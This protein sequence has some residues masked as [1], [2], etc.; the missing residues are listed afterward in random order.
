MHQN[1]WKPAPM[2]ARGGQRAR[3]LT[4]WPRFF[5]YPAVTLGVLMLV[6]AVGLSH[7]LEGQGWQKI[8]PASAFA[9]YSAAHSPKWDKPLTTLT[10]DNDDDD[11]D[12][13]G[14]D[15]P[16]TVT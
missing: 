5:W 8:S 14:D 9:A 4:F 16:T 7:A 13:N 15:C 1:L 12:D 6:L 2:K 10:S 11:D 3:R